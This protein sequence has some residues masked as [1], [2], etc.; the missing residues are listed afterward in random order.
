[1]K[2]KAPP[3]DGAPLLADAGFDMDSDRR[4]RADWSSGSTVD[5]INIESLAITR[6]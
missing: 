6:M 1:M 3:R 2:I 4:Y 5:F